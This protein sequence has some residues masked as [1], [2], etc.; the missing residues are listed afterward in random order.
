MPTPRPF[1]D[2]RPHAATPAEQAWLAS[3]MYADV[4]R[5]ALRTYRNPLVAGKALARLAAQVRQFSAASGPIRFVRVGSRWYTGVY[6][7]SW[8]SPAFDRWAADALNEVLRW[9]PTGGSMPLVFLAL[10]ER[11]PLTCEHCSA[12]SGPEAPIGLDVSAWIRI[13]GELQAMGVAQ[14]QITGGEALTRFDD[15][16]ALLGSTSAETDVWLLTS[17]VGLTE[18]RARALAEAGLRGVSLSLDHHDLARHAAFRGVAGNGDWVRS[19]ARAVRSAWLPLAFNLVVR[20]EAANTAFLDAYLATAEELGGA[21]VR[22]LEPRA[23]GR[24]AGKSVGLTAEEIEVVERFHEAPRP[25]G[26]QT[27]SD[28]YF[29]RRIGCMGAADAFFEID[30]HGR[31]RSC[32]FC[33]E[34]GGSVVER[35]V[36]EAVAALHGR[37]CGAHRPSRSRPITAS[38]AAGVSR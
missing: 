23:V 20:H 34:D 24:W 13:V 1:A 25:T 6:D 38:A 33:A 11:C 19:A 37:G 21:F 14:I 31:A 4:A 15:L 30:A 10:T 29:V 7:P 22:L 28:G 32:P 9:R 12:A 3:R 35:P 26:P 5:I 2:A 17:G 18:T 16:V 27:F 8:P 36:A